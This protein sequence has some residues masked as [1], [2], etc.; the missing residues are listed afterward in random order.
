MPFLGWDKFLLKTTFFSA[1]AVC[2]R[3]ELVPRTKWPCTYAHFSLL[4]WSV[5]HGVV[6]LWNTGSEGGCRVVL[7]MHGIAFA[8]KL[9][10]LFFYFQNKTAN[11]IKMG[12]MAHPTKA[13]A[14][15]CA[16]YTKPYSAL[17]SNTQ[18]HAHAHTYTHTTWGLR[19][20][21]KMELVAVAAGSPT[22]P[23]DE[24]RDYIIYF[25]FGSTA[26][27]L[28][29]SFNVAGR[30]LYRMI[31]DNSSTGQIQHCNIDESN[32]HTWYLAANRAER[33]HRAIHYNIALKLSSCRLLSFIPLC[34]HAVSALMLSRKCKFFCDEFIQRLR[35]MALHTVAWKVYIFKQI[36][37]INY[38]L[39]VTI[40]NVDLVALCLSVCIISFLHFFFRSKN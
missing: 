20:R 23:N 21:Q 22:R 34:M 6:F 3:E 18:S 40:S 10:V 12:T 26:I 5:W 14:V 27:G 28:C 1:A 31:A 24:Y 37:R 35:K 38:L 2:E 39:D 13:I 9:F 25:G 8:W 33:A 19:L 16:A 15:K 4:L 29:T 36:F 30:Q 11:A 17:G 32:L 7:R